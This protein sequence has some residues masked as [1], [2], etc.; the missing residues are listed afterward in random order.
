MKNGAETGEGLFG[1]PQCGSAGLSDMRG[2]AQPDRPVGYADRGAQ[3]KIPAEESAEKITA[4]KAEL[5]KEIQQKARLKKQLDQLEAAQEKEQKQ[6]ESQ[7]TQ[8]ASLQSQE[9]AAVQK[10]KVLREQLSIEDPQKAKEALDS[11]RKERA[12][13]EKM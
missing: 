8:L 11:L 5:E 6:L 10:A 3:G 4:R 13:Y 2:T 1:K 9:A 7:K 12:V